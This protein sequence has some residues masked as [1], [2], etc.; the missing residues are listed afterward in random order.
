MIKINS[1]R[2]GSLVINNKKYDNDMTVHWDGEVIPREST[3][4]FSRNELMDL[5]LKGPEIIV[6]GTGTAGCVV[7]DKN[8]EKLAKNKNVELII[9]KTPDA[10]EDFNKLTKDKKVIAVLHVTC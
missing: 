2:F 8:A 3:H 5:L 4:E 6:I 10:V 9:K 1:F 7:I